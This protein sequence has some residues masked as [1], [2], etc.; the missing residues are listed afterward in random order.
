[1]RTGLLKFAILS[2]SLCLFILRTEASEKVSFNRDIRPILA[3]RCFAYHGPD[4]EFREADLRL[5]LKESALA[6]ITPK[7][8][9]KSEF[10]ERISSSAPE[11]QMPPAE[12]NKPLSKEQIQLPRQWGPVPM[13]RTSEH[14]EGNSRLS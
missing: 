9:N 7:K 3:D 2:I 11:L 5:D 8:S 13:G 6:V 12:F 14:I 10:V 4:A 1:M